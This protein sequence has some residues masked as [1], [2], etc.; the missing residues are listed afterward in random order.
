MHSSALTV[1]PCVQLAKELTSV[2]GLS[3]G[4]IYFF[5]ALV[6]VLASIVADL[7]LKLHGCHIFIFPIHRTAISLGNYS[8]R[9]KRLDISSCHQITDNSLSALR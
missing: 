1:I 4:Q 7:M 2:V 3:F 5:K 6:Y 9:L 8:G